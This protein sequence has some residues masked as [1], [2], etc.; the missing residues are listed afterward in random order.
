MTITK[1]EHE[2]VKQILHEEI[3]KRDKEIAKLQDENKILIKTSVKRN[4]EL[5][6]LQE[7]LYPKY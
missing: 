5:K 1:E 4:L 3:L 7:K 6:E 2:R